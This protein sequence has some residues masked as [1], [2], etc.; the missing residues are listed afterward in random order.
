MKLVEA[1]TPPKPQNDQDIKTLYPESKDVP[2]EATPEIFSALEQYQL[3]KDDIETRQTQL[4]AVAVQIKD[5]MGDADT[6]VDAAGTKIVT[7]KSSKPRETLDTK[8]LKQDM[9]EVYERFKKVSAV[10]ARP[11]KVL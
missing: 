3:I 9:P 8:A 2:I 7:Y 5:F 10:G 6:L 4:E 11:F 1:K